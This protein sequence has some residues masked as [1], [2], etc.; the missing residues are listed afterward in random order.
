MAKVVFVTYASGEFIKNFR[1][2]HFFIRVFFRPDKVYFFTDQDLKRASIF[3]LNERI[4][5]DTIGAGFWAWKPW[6]ILQAVRACDPDDI[7]VYHDCGRGIRYKTFNRLKN[8]IHHAKCNDIFPGVAVP[9][10]GTNEQWT[11]DQCF[12][13][14]QCN[15]SKYRQAPQVE[16]S[17]SAWKAGKRSDDFLKEWLNYCLIWDAISDKPARLTQRDNFIE[18]RY[19]QSILTNLVYKHGLQPAIVSF[20]EKQ[21]SKAIS[22]VDLKLGNGRWTSI[23]MITLLEFFISVRRL[24][25]NI[26]KKLRLS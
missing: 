11:H 4:F 9:S 1:W 23:I 24:V 5:S 18:H 3:S 8:I 10:H 25:T 2:N 19:D 20:P 6:A 14:M 21:L 12:D 16:A 13:V 7:V 15:A 26:F 17:I 22:Y